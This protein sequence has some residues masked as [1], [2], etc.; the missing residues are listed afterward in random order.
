M[1]V[2]AGAGISILI[3]YMR[4][5]LFALS[6][7]ISEHDE[8]DC[9]SW[10]A[11]RRSARPQVLLP[12]HPYLVLFGGIKGPLVPCF[13]LEDREPKC[14]VAAWTLLTQASYIKRPQW[15]LKHNVFLSGYN[16]K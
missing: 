4:D 8:S 11:Q 6:E 14:C 2:D 15:K 10:G 7:Q 3:K 12:P 13:F 16:D 5:R 9:D 1:A